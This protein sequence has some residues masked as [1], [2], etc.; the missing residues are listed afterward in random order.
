MSDQIETEG[1][2][3]FLSDGKGACY[4]QMGRKNTKAL[5]FR[6]ANDKFLGTLDWEANISNTWQFISGMLY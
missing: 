1:G 2:I 5:E 3:V 4:S 6:D